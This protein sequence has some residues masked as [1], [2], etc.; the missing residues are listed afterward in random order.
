M[1]AAVRW[2]YFACP[3]RAALRLAL[4][5]P[6]NHSRLCVS[7]TS[8]EIIRRGTGHTGL[9]IFVV[10]IIQFFLADT[11]FEKMF[12]TEDYTWYRYRSHWAS[13]Q[14]TKRTIPRDLVHRHR[15]AP[16]PPREDERHH[17]LGPAPQATFHAECDLFSRDPKC[18]GAH[19]RSLF[20]IRNLVLGAQVGRT[21]APGAASGATATAA[22]AAIEY[23]TAGPTYARTAR[24][25]LQEDASAAADAHRQAQGNVLR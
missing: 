22:T 11:Y 17:L 7:S 19:G 10:G 2:G 9:E 21:R 23:A 20:T 4:S 1:S 5:L 8:R 24:R 18:Q 13:Q 6:K 16:S 25:A 3:P 12:F 15:R 14:G